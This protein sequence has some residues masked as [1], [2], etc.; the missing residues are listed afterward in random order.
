LSTTNL[1]TFYCYFS[2]TW[3]L[4]LGGRAHQRQ[5]KTYLVKLSGGC[6]WRA[7]DSNQ[8]IGTQ[9]KEEEHTRRLNWAVPLPRKG[10]GLARCWWSIDNPG[11]GWNKTD[12]ILL[13]RVPRV[14]L[15]DGMRSVSFDRKPGT[16]CHFIINYKYYEKI[17][18]YVYSSSITWC[19]HYTCIFHSYNLILT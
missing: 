10:T 15:I 12:R 4:E 5:L 14:A 3:E 1:Y 6:D 11:F 13:C 18:L 19:G 2:S 16:Q 9:W 7:L 8:I 17:I